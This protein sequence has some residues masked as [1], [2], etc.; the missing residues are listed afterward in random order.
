[1]GGPPEGDAKRTRVFVNDS[2]HSRRPAP[3][4]ETATAPPGPGWPLETPLP[5]PV[6]KVASTRSAAAAAAPLRD[7][8]T[9]RERLHLAASV[10]LL[11]A[12]LALGLLVVRA[13]ISAEDVP[14]RPPPAA[15]SRAQR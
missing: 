10:L 15:P 5:P 4:T 8:H 13:R 3:I 6:A 9:T 2:T 1:M 7:Y 11:L 14:V 12:L